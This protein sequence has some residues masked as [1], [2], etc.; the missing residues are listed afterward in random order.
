MTRDG[1][2]GRSDATESSL[3]LHRDNRSRSNDE[4]SVRG[5]HQGQQSIRTASTGRTHD[6]KR[7]L[8]STPNDLLPGG[9]HPHMK[10]RPVC[11]C[12]QWRKKPPGELSIAPVADERLGWATIWVGA[13]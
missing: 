10:V 3:P 2:V 8:C 1:T 13:S 9:G 5:P 6:C 12:C 11:V 4:A 7:P